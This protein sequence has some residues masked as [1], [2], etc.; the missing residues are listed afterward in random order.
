MY[1]WGRHGD[2]LAFPDMTSICGIC[3]SSLEDYGNQNLD[4]LETS[5]IYCI[6]IYS[7][8]TEEPIYAYFLQDW[9]ANIKQY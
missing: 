9:K 2:L 3:G 4:L 5:S 7:L 8:N 6:Y 1:I